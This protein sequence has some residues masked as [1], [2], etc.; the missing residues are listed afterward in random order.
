MGLEFSV[1]LTQTLMAIDV[2]LPFP[3]H[4]QVRTVNDHNFFT[5]RIFRHILL[6]MMK[7]ATGGSSNSKIYY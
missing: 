4:V 2:W 1:D 7:S 6:R 5:R 3:E